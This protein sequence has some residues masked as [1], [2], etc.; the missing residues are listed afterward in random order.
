MNPV[1]TLSTRFQISLLLFYFA[2]CLAKWP[3]PLWNCYKGIWIWS[4]WFWPLL[5][6]WE[7]KCKGRDVFVGAPLILDCWRT[8]C[9]RHR[10]MPLQRCCRNTT[11]EGSCRNSSKGCRINVCVCVFLRKVYIWKSGK[12][13]VEKGQ[14]ISFLT[15]GCLSCPWDPY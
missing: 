12:E 1:S 15:S 14:E 4:L 2:M 5:K 8:E 6:S 9:W 7:G 11:N 3:L 10:Q 13:W